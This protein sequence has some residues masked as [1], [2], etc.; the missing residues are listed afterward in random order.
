ME[1]LNTKFWLQ[2]DKVYVQKY[3]GVSL[4]FKQ[5]MSTIPK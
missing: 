5:K 3:G 4:K 1:S 2:I